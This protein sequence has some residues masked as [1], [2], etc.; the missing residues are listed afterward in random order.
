M[1]SDRKFLA[2]AAVIVGSLVTFRV[3]PKA[4]ILSGFLLLTA[5]AFIARHVRRG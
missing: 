1:S 4:G 3:E 2:L 5:L